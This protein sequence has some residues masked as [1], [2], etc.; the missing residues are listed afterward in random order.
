VVTNAQGSVIVAEL[1]PGSYKVRAELE[2]FSAVEFPNFEI[3]NGKMAQ[4]EITLTPA[5]EETITVTAEA[6]LLD[7]RRLSTGMT[8]SNR[9][10]RPISTGSTVTQKE[11]E[12]IPT[13]SD[14][15]TVLS[16][17]LKQGLVGG[18]KPLPVDIP[19]SGKA[20]LL[21]GALPPAKVAVEIEVK[22]KG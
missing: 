2:G 20:L 8:F 13:A 11:L 17:E 9:A 10:D 4:L 18:V 15:W 3:Q 6:P 14:P 16:S 5:I 19:E 1:Q 7:E 21:S 22:G 12:K